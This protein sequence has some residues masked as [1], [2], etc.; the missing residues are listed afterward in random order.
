MKKKTISEN[1]IPKRLKQLLN[2]TVRRILTGFIIYYDGLSAIWGIT[3]HLIEE[4]IRYRLTSDP[5]SVLI[6]YE[7]HGLVLFIRTCKYD[8]VA[9]YEIGKRNLKLK[10]VEIKRRN[11]HCSY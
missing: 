1:R 2:G 6:R 7:N 9:E 5:V 10:N 8:V 3:E 4:I 11:K